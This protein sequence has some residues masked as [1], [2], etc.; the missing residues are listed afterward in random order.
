MTTWDW[1][2]RNGQL[3]EMV[4][5][6]SVMTRRTLH[7]MDA[8]RIRELRESSVL[9]QEALARTIGVAVRTVARWE[10]GVSKPSPMAIEKLNQ[11]LSGSPGS[12][13]K[14]SKEE[15]V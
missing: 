4:V 12:G 10:S 9:S 14:L 11:V 1:K 6:T 15:R 3:F 7:L 5:L 2:G 13:G 8:D